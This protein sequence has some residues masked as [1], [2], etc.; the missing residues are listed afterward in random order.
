MPRQYKSLINNRAP[1]LAILLV[2]FVLGEL[3]FL[4]TLVPLD[5]AVY[6]WVEYYRGCES[7]RLLSVDWPLG[8]LVF[9]VLIVGCYLCVR[10]HWYDAWHGTA[11]IVVGGFLA[12]LLKTVFERARPS[13]ISPLL[14]G[15]SFPSGHTTGAVLLA[16]TLAFWLVRQHLS[17]RF[18]AGGLIVLGSFVCSVIVQRVYLMHHWVSDILGT[19]PLAMAWLCVTLALP[20]GRNA[21]RP[22][23][24][25]CSVLCV[26]YPLFYHIPALRIHLP[27]ALSTVREPTLSFSFG[28]AIT[29]TL[30]QGAWGENGQETIGA[31]T[32][33]QHG[34]AS[35]AVPLQSQHGY[36]MR[37]SARPFLH[38][39][40]FACFPLEVSLNK[41]PVRRL[42]LSRGWREYELYLDPAWVTPGINTVTFR[43]GAGFPSANLEQEAVAFHKVALFAE[44][45]GTSVAE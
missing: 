28:E 11:I 43:T 23:V 5:A 19:V 12:E 18:K 16:G 15:N 34:E 45:K 17:V 44:G 9:L 25:A 1:R 7:S 32:W 35:I 8:A 10:G 39:K 30:L 26:A 40:S 24:F 20:T 31:I 21:I 37:F 2:I 13:G 36:S 38:T 27:S 6:N 22:I 3:L 29:P 14:V 41:H 33:M 4:S 42:L